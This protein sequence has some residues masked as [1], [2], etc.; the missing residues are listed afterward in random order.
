MSLANFGCRGAFGIG[1]FSFAS[2]SDLLDMPLENGLLSGGRATH[3]SECRSEGWTIFM[4][5]NF[6]NT[7]GCA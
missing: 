1:P 2:F 4:H 7:K 5:G 3:L 6:A